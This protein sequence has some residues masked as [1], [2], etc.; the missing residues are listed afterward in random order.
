MP[1]G[2]KK[3]KPKA[4]RALIQQNKTLTEWPEERSI[5]VGK[6]CDTFFFLFLMINNFSYL[7]NS[8]E[9]KQSVV[10]REDDRKVNIFTV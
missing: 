10:S 6:V 2:H 3:R 7:R 5:L 9:K 4:P 1:H 8:N